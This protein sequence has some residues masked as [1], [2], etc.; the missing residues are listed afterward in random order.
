MPRRP[1]A[2]TLLLWFLAGCTSWRVQNLTPQQIIDRW[3]PTSVRVTTADSSEFVL[4]QPEIAGGD[5]LA[6]LERGAPSSV[7]VSDVTQVAIR[8]FSTGKTVG[9]VAGIFVVAV[10]IA[11]A[12]ALSNM[13]ML[14]GWG[15]N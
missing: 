4:D 7:A 1:I 13:C 2:C 5:S 10:S 14:C 12:I 3:H 8:K 6:G 11:A 9:L 15:G